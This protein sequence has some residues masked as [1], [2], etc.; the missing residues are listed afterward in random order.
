LTFKVHPLVFE[1][2]QPS[3]VA[4]VRKQY[5]V[6]VLKLFVV[7][8]PLGAQLISFGD[9]HGSDPTPQVYVVE[10]AL[11]PPEPVTP[12]LLLTPPELV[13]P[14]DDPED[15]ANGLAPLF[16]PAAA[17]VLPVVPPEEGGVVVVPPAPPAGAGFVP[18]VLW[19]L[20][21]PGRTALGSGPQATMKRAA[22][23]TTNPRMAN[24][25]HFLL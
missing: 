4:M 7:P 12:P 6:V 1:Q 18:P 22:E 9:A 24:E 14:P 19:G 25:Q 3:I 15:P 16:P 20:A 17:D 2:P 11:D 8:L 5:S 13:T 23:T 10:S 21:I